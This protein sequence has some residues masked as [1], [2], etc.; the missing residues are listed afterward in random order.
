MIHTQDIAVATVL[1][2]SLAVHQEPYITFYNIAKLVNV[3]IPLQG[4][5]LFPTVYGM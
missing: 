5:F 3:L 1:S 4:Y 2:G